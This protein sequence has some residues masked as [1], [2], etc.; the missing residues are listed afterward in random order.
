MSSKT[1]NSSS[2]TPEEEKRIQREVEE[3]RKRDRE[4]IIQAEIQNRIAN[5]ARARGAL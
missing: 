1:K 2:F 3:Y 4:A 5:D